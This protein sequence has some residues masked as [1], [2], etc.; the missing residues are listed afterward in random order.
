MRGPHFGSGAQ[1]EGDS[2]SRKSLSVGCLRL[3]IL[4]RQTYWL[5]VYVGSLA[6]LPWSGPRGGPRHS[7][8]GARGAG[9]SSGLGF[10]AQGS[11]ACDDLDWAGT[12]HGRSSYGDDLWGSLGGWKMRSTPDS[13]NVRNAVGLSHCYL[14]DLGASV[15]KKTRARGW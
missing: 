13:F 10:G 5:P 11:A 1:E 14:R 8:P 9:W 4:G 15:N 2:A 6:P 12:W 7:R 3:W